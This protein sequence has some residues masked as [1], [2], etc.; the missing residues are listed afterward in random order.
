MKKL[1]VLALCLASIGTIGAQKKVVDQANKLAGKTEK[2]AEARSLINQAMQDPETANQARTYYVAGLIEWK[3]YD[4]ERLLKDLNKGTVS[5]N[6]MAQQLLDGYNYFMKALE[7]DKIPDEKG[8]VDKFANDI[9]SQLAGHERDFWGA[10]ATYFNDGKYYPE[11]YNGFYLSADIPSMPGMEKY[12]AQMLPDS[13]RA[14]SYFNAGRAAFYGNEVKKA[15]EAFKKATDMGLNDPNGYVFQIAC[16]ENLANNDST[17]QQEATDNILALSK[18]GYEKYGTNPPIFLSQIVDKL[19]SNGK[20]QEALDIV[21][22]KI[23]TQPSALLYRLRGWVYGRMN[24]EEGLVNDYLKAASLDD[25]DADILFNSAN[26]LYRY[27]ANKNG[28]IAGNTAEDRAT[29]QNL[30]DNYL[31]PALD[32]AQKAKQMN[33]DANLAKRI[34]NLIEDIEYLMPKL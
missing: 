14:Q 24:N 30:K 23:N 16:W 34:N 32:F 31:T 7:L 4:N 22:G 18:A 10:G 13:T 15:N 6:E 19:A 25:A 29:K 12:A 26:V 3:A 20:A 9:N 28:A 27:V 8:K 33:D 11:A 1:F 5:D 2:L 17:L 21:N